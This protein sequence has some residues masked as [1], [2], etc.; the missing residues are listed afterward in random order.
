[1]VVADVKRNYGIFWFAWVQRG[2]R[3]YLLCGEDYQGYNVID[4][5]FGP[6]VLTFPHEAYK[7]M[8]F[9]WTAAYPSPTGDTIAVEGC[10][11]ACP[12]ELVFYD[13]TNPSRSPLPELFRVEDLERAE[14]WVSDHEF[15]FT[16]GEGAS[17]RSETWRRER[18]SGPQ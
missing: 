17:Q 7:G 15:R 11:W 16:V 18:A 4:L 12:Y 5:N 9:C 10:Y 1:M 6:N 14:G 2:D 8:G 3:E 13:F